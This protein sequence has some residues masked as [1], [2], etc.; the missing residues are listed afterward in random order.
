MSWYLREGPAPAES[1][2][3]IRRPLM[4][5]EAF[6]MWVNAGHK[7]DYERR[8]NPIWRELEDTLV[9]HGVCS[10]TIFLDPASRDLFG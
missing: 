2:A 8:H 10:Y 5:C 3:T 6:R 7:A 9:R 4:L 1:S